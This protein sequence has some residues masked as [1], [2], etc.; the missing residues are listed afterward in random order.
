[1]ETK[2][3]PGIVRRAFT[4]VDGHNAVYCRTT[5]EGYKG[6]MPFSHHAILGT[7]GP[8]G[9]LLVSTSNFL[10]GRT[11]PVPSAN[12]A[13]GEYQFLAPDAAFRS[14]SRVPSIFRNRPPCDCSSF[15]VRRGFGDLLQQFEQ[16]GRAR[17]IPS[18]VTAVNIEKGWMWFAFKDPGLMPGRLF[19]IENHGRHSPPWNGRNSCLG[20]EDGC[21]YFDRGIAASARPNPI[22]RSGIP[23]SLLF[24]A[25]RNV[26]IRYIQGA[27]RVPRGF[28]RVKQV[29]FIQGAAV[30]Q[31]ESGGEVTVPVSHGFL[32]DGIL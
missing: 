25:H 29:R 26:E 7:A 23:T 19:W 21:M 15:P 22:N 31:S 11:Y 17:A 5:L 1:L 2:V 8:E 30:F 12:P 18:W 27:V 20:I 3:R 10:I 16:P 24:P 6:R 13:A 9:T 32:F 28:D 4:L 14:L